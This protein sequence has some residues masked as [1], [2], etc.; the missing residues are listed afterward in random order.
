M[1]SGSQIF[2]ASGLNLKMKATCPAK[3]L[4]PHHVEW[5]ALEVEPEVMARSP[6]R[7][8]SAGIRNE[9]RMAEGLYSLPLVRAPSGRERWPGWWLVLFPR[10]QQS[11]GYGAHL[12]PSTFLWAVFPLIAR[13][14]SLITRS[15]VPTL[16]KRREGSG[17]SCVQLVFIEHLL[18]TEYCC[19][20]W[21]YS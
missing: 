16:P 15:I 3:L 4:L 1:I 19:Q 10:P 21:G 14:R 18:H 9:E 8:F 11:P 12:E 13:W 2:R 5:M 17:D 6:G 7:V 20:H